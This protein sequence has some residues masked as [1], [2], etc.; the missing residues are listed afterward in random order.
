MILEA[1]RYPIIQAPMAGGPSTLAL[2]LAVTNAG[3][4]GF[5]ATG[6]GRAETTRQE[7]RELRSNTDRPFG[8]NVFIPAADH[9]DEQAVDVYLQTLDSEARRYGVEVGEPRNEEDEWSSFFAV[10]VDE[11]PPAVSFTFGCPAAQEIAE[12]QA[13]GVSV[14]V[15]VIDPAEAV[16]AHA[17][18]VNALIV[19]GVEA[20]GHR[21]GFEDRLDGE[22]L[23]LLPL[24]RLTA[25]ACDLPLIAAGGIADGPGLAAVLSAGAAAAQIGTAFMLAD[26][27]ATHPAHR[28]ALATSA[29]TGLTRAFSGRQARGIVNR[30]QV[31]HADAPRAYP[32]IHYA[33]SPLRAQARKLGDS[34][35][36]NLWAG[37]A[38]SLAK[39]RPAAEIVEGIAAGA[40][41]ALEDA[42]ARVV[43]KG[44]G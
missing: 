39:A 6:Y 29:A 3:A 27:A 25:K 43:G 30:F 33:T 8:V 7:I 36:F 34:D 26:E 10:L 17:A 40:A 11:R 19:Q 18:G 1:L 31:D 12:L 42:T 5:L 44:D 37:Q 13:H 2:A 28:E 4:M 15:T 20:G 9:F 14:W 32:Q 22:D 35:G 24:L 23:A 41:A 16:F 21:G 38:H